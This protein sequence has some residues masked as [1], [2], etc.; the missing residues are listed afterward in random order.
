MTK[1]NTRHDGTNFKR[2]REVDVNGNSNLKKRE[3]ARKS[4]Y[5]RVVHKATPPP[6]KNI[7]K[8]EDEEQHS[9]MEKRLNSCKSLPRL[10]PNNLESYM[11]D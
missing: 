8:S 11:L 4:N 2:K 5:N 1:Q 9:N 3:R 6:D 7:S 10:L